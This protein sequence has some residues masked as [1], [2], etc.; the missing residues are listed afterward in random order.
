MTPWRVGRGCFG[1]TREHRCLGEV[2]LIDAAAK[3]IPARRLDSVDAVTHI[4]DVEVQLEDLLLGQRVLD[5]TRE[6]ELG[7]LLPQRAGWIFSNGECIARDLHRDGAESFTRA[8]G[9]DV[10]DD[11]PEEAAPV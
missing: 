2:E 11:C 1:Q 5:E 9:A 10:G 4:D 7:E 6:S 3:E 8:P